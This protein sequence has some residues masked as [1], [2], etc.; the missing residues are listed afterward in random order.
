MKHSI[1][2]YIAAMVAVLSFLLFPM[3]ILFIAHSTIPTAVAVL[4]FTMNIL[5]FAMSAYIVCKLEK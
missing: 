2:Y 4:M 5:L 1:I 3:S